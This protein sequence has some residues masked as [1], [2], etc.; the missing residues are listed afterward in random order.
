MPWLEYQA[1]RDNLSTRPATNKLGNWMIILCLSKLQIGDGNMMVWENISFGVK[2]NK[3][4]SQT[5]PCL[6]W[7][8][9]IRVWPLE[10][11]VPSSI[12]IVYN[13]V[14]LMELWEWT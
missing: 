7:E 4:A 2:G 10:F 12:E 6:L 13:A 14:C 1:L 5:D 9:E 11:S 8:P 3:I